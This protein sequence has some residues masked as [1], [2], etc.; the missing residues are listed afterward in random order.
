MGV[1][2]E[3]GQDIEGG[4]AAEAGEDDE[5]GE[6]SEPPCTPMGE[7]AALNA[8]LVPPA[9]ESPAVA[10]PKAAPALLA[11]RR[12]VQ[13][14]PLRTITA[15]LLVSV[16]LAFASLAIFELVQTSGTSQVEVQTRMSAHD[17]ASALGAYARRDSSLPTVQLDE[18]QGEVGRVVGDMSAEDVATTLN[19]YARMHRH[20]GHALLSALS[21]RAREVV[22]DM[23][24][25]D[26]TDVVSAYAELGERL[27]RPGTDAESRVE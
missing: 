17:V 5:V 25:Q 15:T 24:A 23:S 2:I 14:S 27:V 11:A 22:G 4:G 13:L 20:P 7:E 1:T 26:V 10:R 16:G 6:G 9:P 21:S 8:P 18:L 12:D 3:T 19:A